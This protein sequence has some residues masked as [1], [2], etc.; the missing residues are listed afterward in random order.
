LRSGWTM[1]TSA[2]Y[3]IAMTDRPMMIGA[4]VTDAS[5]SSGR[6]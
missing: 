1:L 6:L 3:R 2:P 5:G 4:N